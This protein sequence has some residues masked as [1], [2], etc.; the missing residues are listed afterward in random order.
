M[1]YKDK[2]K[3][4]QFQA[5]WYVNHKVKQAQRQKIKRAERA[6]WFFKLKSTYSCKCGEDH[7]ACL[8]FHHRD[9]PG[10]KK[11]KISMMVHQ[12]YTIKA[13][14]EEIAKCD[15]LCS[16]CHRKHHYQEW[17]KQNGVYRTRSGQ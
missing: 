3:Q 14:L 10:N 15:V 11:S 16:N 7:P 8:D 17:K 1:P 6:E 12:A 13:I 2:I 4:K 5:T 9:G